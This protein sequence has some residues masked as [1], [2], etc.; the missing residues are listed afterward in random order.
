MIA[1][2]RVL[3]PSKPGL[4]VRALGALPEHPAVG[5]SGAIV[6][7][8]DGLE[9]QLLLNWYADIRASPPGFSLGLVCPYRMC[10]PQLGNFLFPVAPVLAPEALHDPA[11]LLTAIRTVREASIEGRILEEVVDERGAEVL[12]ARPLLECLISHAVRGATLRSAARDQALAEETVRARLKRFGIQP[13]HFMSRWR[14]RAY[15]LRREA[16]ESAHA[17]LLAGGWQ[18]H[19]ARREAQRRLRLRGT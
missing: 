18:D 5:Y 1:L 7:C 3:P 16:G 2:V 4:A 12:E 6:L 15:Q 17:A 19:D 9:V 13:G 14:I 10:A 11:L 8:G